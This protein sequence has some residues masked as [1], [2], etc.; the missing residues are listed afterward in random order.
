MS[1]DHLCYF[2]GNYALF[3][4]TFRQ[5][6]VLTGDLIQDGLY[7]VMPLIEKIVKFSVTHRFQSHVIFWL[8]VALVFM[9]RYD[10][11]EYKDLDKILLY[12]CNDAGILFFGLYDHSK[13]DAVKE[14][15]RGYTLFYWW[16]LPDF[17]LFSISCC[18]SFRTAH[19][20][21]SF[22][23]GIDR[24]DSHRP[25]KTDYALL[26]AFLFYGVGIRFCEVDS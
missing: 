16:L 2:V 1:F 4:M 19:Q 24:T 20:N 6:I 8:T 12:V 21:F 13:A 15:F 9:N 18:L 11:E 26:C 23:S 22:Q 5:S 10:I 14:L 3:R 7:L 17:C 25:S